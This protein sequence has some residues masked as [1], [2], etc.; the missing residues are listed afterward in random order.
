MASKKIIFITGANTGI[1]YALVEALLSSSKP[2]HVIVG[3]RSLDKGQEA[4]D[5]LKKQYSDSASSLELVQIDITSDESILTAFQ[6]ISHSHD[7]LD[8]LV[9]NAGT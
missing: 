2:Y 3:S 8:A 4:I 6:T 9:N 5:A 1:G 7:R